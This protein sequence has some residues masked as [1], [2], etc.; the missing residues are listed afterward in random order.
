MNL[1]ALQHLIRA[2][3]ALAENQSLIVL[4]S[5]SLLASFPEL[6]KNQ[7]PLT[8]TFDADLYPV[9]LMNWSP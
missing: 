6:G 8:T 9:P 2:A 7:G 5:S 1:S 4:G 3:Q